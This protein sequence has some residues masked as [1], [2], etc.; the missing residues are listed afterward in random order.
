MTDHGARERGNE[1]AA[2]LDQLLA[3]HHADLLR[4]VD[5]AL[6]IGVGFRNI[7]AFAARSG[8]DQGEV[9]LAALDGNPP[10]VPV[11]PPGYAHERD[12]SE[13]MRGVLRDIGNEQRFLDAF[14]QHARSHAAWLV[15]VSSAPTDGTAVVDVLLAAR[16]A[17]GDFAYGLLGNGLTQSEAVA[18]LDHH[19]AALQEQLALWGTF[20][21]DPSR[22][23]LG[24]SRSY[25][26]LRRGLSFRIQAMSDLRKAVIRLFSHSDDTEMLPS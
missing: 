2:A 3:Q 21:R 8:L 17:L 25:I 16:E 24:K 9:D 11:H 6:V 19:L 10:V 22:E 23:A 20:V 15:D 12:R 5:K 1:D 4:S 18:V 7:T 26:H 14:A 13:A